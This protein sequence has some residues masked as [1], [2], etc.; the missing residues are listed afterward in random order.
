[1]KTMSKLILREWHALRPETGFFLESRDQNGGK[2]FLKGCMQRCEA[3]NQNKRVYPRSMLQRE[4]Q[5]Y[6]KNV[7]ENRS[8]GELDHPETSTVSLERASHAVREM[9]W[10]GDTWMGR[11][12][13]LNTPCG[14]IAE[15][16]LNAGVAVGISSRGVGSTKT[17]ESGFDAVDDDFTLV[18]FDL[19]AEPSTHGAFMLP[20][21]VDPTK[22]RLSLSRA[23]RINRALNALKRR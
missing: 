2:L 10:D 18:A 19:V 17:N 22:T 14:R 3:P 5:N 16:L 7:S 13:I 21:S 11:I 4:F 9:W 8:L 20:E 6:T 1:M 15:E 12:E 23:D